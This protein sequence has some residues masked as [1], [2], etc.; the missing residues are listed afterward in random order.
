[1]ISS[2]LELQQHSCH[3]VEAAEFLVF[4]YVGQHGAVV[5]S[6]VASKPE[7]S[8]PPSAQDR[9]VWRLHF[10]PVFVWVLRLPPTVQTCSLWG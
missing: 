9:S 7:G 3:K 1:M 2:H 4:I 8:T 6:T 5:V 10:L